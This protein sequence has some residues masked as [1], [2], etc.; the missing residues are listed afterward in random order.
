[1]PTYFIHVTGLNIELMLVL[2]FVCQLNPSGASEPVS[3]VIIVIYSA[4]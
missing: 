4:C 1:M 3:V 2:F